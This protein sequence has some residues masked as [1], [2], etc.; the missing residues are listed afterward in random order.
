MNIKEIITCF[1][2]NYYYSIT[3]LFV[4]LT[5]LFSIGLHFFTMNWQRED[6]ED[7]QRSAKKRKTLPSVTVASSKWGLFVSPSVT[8]VQMIHLYDLFKWFI[9]IF[10]IFCLSIQMV[11][12]NESSKWI[13]CLF[14]YFYFHPNEFSKQIT[15]IPLSWFNHMLKFTTI[16]TSNKQKNW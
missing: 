2:L 10:G 15:K 4:T 5:Y 6:M 14:L 3:W 13:L 1:F 16:I 7:W 12:L 8:F 9:Q 11:H